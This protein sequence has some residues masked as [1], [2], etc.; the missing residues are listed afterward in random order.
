MPG[1]L[2]AGAA[3]LGSAGRVLGFTSFATHLEGVLGDGSGR[4]LGFASFRTHLEEV[5]GDGSATLKGVVGNGSPRLEGGGRP[6]LKALADFR[7][8][9]F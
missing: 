3:Q 4:V 9:K 5:F 7:F 1:A 6:A 8:R 2:R